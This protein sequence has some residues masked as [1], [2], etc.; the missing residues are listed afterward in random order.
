MTILENFQ[1]I[2]P[3]PVLTR[4]S[5]IQQKIGKLQQQLNSAVTDG[6]FQAVLEQA[7]VQQTEKIKP[8]EEF[9]A[10]N[11]LQSLDHNLAASIQRM[12]AALQSEE[13]PVQENVAQAT[14]TENAAPPTTEQLIVDAARKFG[15]EA[16]LVK[17]VARAES[18]LSQAARSNV[19]AIGVMQ[20]MPET[21]ASL[22]VNPYDEG[23]N[24]QGGA[25]Y[26]R[27]MLDKFNG[28]LQNAIAAYNAGPGAVQQ[29]GGV[30]PYG[31]TQAYVGRVLGMYE[32]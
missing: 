29:Y 15:V 21:A 20:L 17:A 3:I 19:G 13:T 4:I 26:L 22:G 18:N 23:Q 32:S 5:E 27:Q 11:P 24:I 7:M 8:I 25:H 12:D 2:S 31:E 1:A 10:E 14:R 28:N 6:K 9:L 30:P 16:D